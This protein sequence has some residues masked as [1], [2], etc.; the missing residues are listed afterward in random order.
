MSVV[1]K[2]KELKSMAESALTDE[3]VAAE[4]KTKAK[5]SMAGIG[6]PYYASEEDGDYHLGYRHGDRYVRYTFDNGKTWSPAR[7]F[8]KPLEVSIPSR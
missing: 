5:A 8:A 7:E 3:A 1:N 4:L 6:W 2:A